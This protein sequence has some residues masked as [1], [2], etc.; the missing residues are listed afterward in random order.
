MNFPI[1]DCHY[2]VLSD[3]WGRIFDLLDWAD[4]HR[5]NL[6]CNQ[7]H[8][9]L[10][11]GSNSLLNQCVLNLLCV[12]SIAQIDYISY[13]NLPFDK[14]NVE[15]AKKKLKKHD[16]LLRY[17]VM[18]P[19][20][21]RPDFQF[22]P[23]TLI[24][25]HQLALR[26]GSYP[27]RL[28][29]DKTILCVNAI[30]SPNSKYTMYRFVL[31]MPY[32]HL[33]SDEINCTDNDNKNMLTRFL[34]EMIELSD[35]RLHIPGYL[36]GQISDSFAVVFLSFILMV[37]VF[38]DSDK[39]VQFFEILQKICRQVTQNQNLSFTP[40]KELLYVSTDMQTGGTV[41]SFPFERQCVVMR[42][43]NRNNLF[44]YEY[45]A[46]PLNRFSQIKYPIAYKSY[47]ETC[48]LISTV[49]SN[50]QLRDSLMNYYKVFLPN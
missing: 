9:W 33:F 43:L 36:P 28:G 50:T 10:C 34:Y 45:R 17:F 42:F 26:I 14:Y 24:E 1:P 16:N 3:I 12:I 19:L 27:G 18:S 38:G 44:S 15:T 5:L 20:L 35:E 39:L 32:F 41:G 13:Q 7:W 49:E 47:L 29:K 46:Y 2:G 40:Y 11:V 30:Q 23:E 31:I 22:E 25:L 4:L 21:N 8:Q 48:L 37:I 6:T